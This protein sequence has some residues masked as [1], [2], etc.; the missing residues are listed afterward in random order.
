MAS[1][2]WRYPASHIASSIESAMASSFMASSAAYRR[3]SWGTSAR[4]RGGPPAA[5]SVPP[6]RIA[7]DRRRYIDRPRHL[8]AVAEQE[9]LMHVAEDQT[10]A[11]LPLVPY[12][13]RL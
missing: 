7:K 12:R 11:L 10:G 4:C 2:S 8:A 1:V 3:H 9:N 6:S 5:W 13:A